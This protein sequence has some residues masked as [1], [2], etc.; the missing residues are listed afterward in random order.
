MG[1]I[2]IQF[3]DITLYLSK[4]RNWKSHGSD[5]IQN[6]WLKAFQATH[7]HITKNFN[8]I[9]EEP[10]KAPDWLTKRITYLIPKS[11]DSKEVGNYR[12]ITCLTTMYKTLTGM[13]AKRISTHLEEQSLLP[14]EQKGCHPGSKGCMDQLMI[15]KAIYEDCRRRNKNLS[16]AWIDYQKAFDSVPHSWM[17]KSIELVGVNSKIVIFCKLFMEKWN[18]R[19]ILKT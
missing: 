10:E 6:Y 1:W 19:L 7:S 2:L 18:T 15:S 9:I 16:I 11:R 17:E 4:A 14:T 8:A 12:P 3:T 5:Q 13:R